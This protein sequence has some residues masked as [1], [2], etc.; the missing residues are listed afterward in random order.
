[1]N[2]ELVNAWLEKKKRRG[3]YGNC[4]LGVAA[5]VSG[6]FVLF[7]TFW[8]T[9]AILWI[10]WPGVSAVSE[11][12]FS[13]KLHMSHEVRLVCSGV[14]IILL[15][16]QHVR[17]CPWHWG[18]YSKVNAVPPG[19]AMHTGVTG[20]FAILLANPQASAN[21][22]ADILLSGPRLVTGSWKLWRTGMNLKRL[23]ITGCAALI[24][25]LA[26]KV[27]AT[28][29]EELRAAGWEEWLD[30]LR[31]L[32][33]VVFLEKGIKLSDDLKRELLAHRQ[34]QDYATV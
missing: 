22:I 24:G 30:H 25:F 2:P 12:I 14:F 15:F 7:L 1:M 17:T 23:D 20:S 11:L 6:L 28:P 8:F 13:K 9:Y 31:L 29:Y 18:D 33:G 19:L 5:L 3:V 4:L 34:N 26:T 32:E 21:I 16:I 10:A 27:N